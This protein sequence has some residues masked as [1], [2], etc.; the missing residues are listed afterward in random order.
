METT[1]IGGEGKRGVNENWNTFSIAQCSKDYKLT[2]RML[3]YIVI[4][5][6]GVPFSC[7]VISIIHT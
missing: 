1:S 6:L 2:W 3:Q 5:C 4:V 7:Q